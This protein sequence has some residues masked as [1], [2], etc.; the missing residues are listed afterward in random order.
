VKETVKLV[1]MELNKEAMLQPQQAAELGSFGH[2]V[3]SLE[4]RIEERG[5]GISL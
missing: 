5:Y 4:S 1:K 2:V 3:L